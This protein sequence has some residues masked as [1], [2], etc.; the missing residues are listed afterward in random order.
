MQNIFIFIFFYARKIYFATHSNGIHSEVYKYYIE[1]WFSL[2]VDLDPY[3]IWSSTLSLNISKWIIPWLASS[4][5][6]YIRVL[7]WSAIIRI[8]KQVEPTYD[9]SYVDRF[10]TETTVFTNNM[11]I[12]YSFITLNGFPA[13]KV[14]TFLWLFFVKNWW[15]HLDWCYTIFGKHLGLDWW[16]NRL[17]CKLV[18]R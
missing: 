4:K 14:L 6:L 8:V 13:L 17:R 7:K 2:P 18:A 3:Y 15:L 9:Q 16:N 10:Q 1:L 5:H 11:N 12:T